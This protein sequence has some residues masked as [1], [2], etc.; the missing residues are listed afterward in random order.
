MSTN[1][2]MY[3]FVMV[4]DAVPP[5][6]SSVTAKS[7][8][9][10]TTDSGTWLPFCSAYIPAFTGFSSTRAQ[11]WYCLPSGASGRLPA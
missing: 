9:L 6:F 8:A 2:I 5:L 1:F 4:G 10:S 7:C 3:I 11:S